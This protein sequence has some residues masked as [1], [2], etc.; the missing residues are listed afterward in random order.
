MP[1][2]ASG[3]ALLQVEEPPSLI[4][5]SLDIER[6]GTDGVRVACRNMRSPVAVI[7]L[8][9]GDDASFILSLLGCENA[10]EHV[11]DQG[12]DSLVS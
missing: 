1:S 8:F 4:P 11:A 12:V 9:R 5:L 10:I 7:H 6:D 3:Y 2:A